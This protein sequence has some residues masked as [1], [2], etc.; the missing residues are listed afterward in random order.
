[1]PDGSALKAGPLLAIQRG[2]G[3]ME[4]NV[5]LTTYAICL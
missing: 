1:M 3:L 5:H 2:F 4:N